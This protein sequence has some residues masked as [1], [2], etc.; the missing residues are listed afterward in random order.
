MLLSLGSATVGVS[1]G[2]GV[3]VGVEVRVGVRVIGE[4][5]NGV[6]VELT[7]IVSVGEAD[8]G[9]STIKVPGF[10]RRLK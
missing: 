10:G 8:A 5:G 4:G 6:L 9:I 2:V 1:V 7:R 3:R